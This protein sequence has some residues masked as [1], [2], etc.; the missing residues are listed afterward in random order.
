MKLAQLGLLVLLALRVH[1]EF[2]ARLVQLAHKALKEFKA[3]LAQLG[4]LAQLV[5]TGKALGLALLIT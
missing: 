1:R 3:R 5:L 2:K 4:L